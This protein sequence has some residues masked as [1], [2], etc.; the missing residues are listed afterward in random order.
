VLL[1]KQFTKFQTIT[2]LQLETQALQNYGNLLK[3]QNPL[4]QQHSITSQQTKSLSNTAVR[5]STL[6]TTQSFYKNRAM[7]IAFQHKTAFVMPTQNHF[8]EAIILLHVIEVTSFHTVLQP[9]F[10]KHFILPQ[11]KLYISIIKISFL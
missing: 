11:Y 7:K 4:A 10:C 3:H 8:P 1:V 6:I 9:K 2:V 5:N